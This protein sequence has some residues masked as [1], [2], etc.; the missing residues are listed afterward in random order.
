MILNNLGK[1][2]DGSVDV[3]ADIGR[4]AR[5]VQPVKRRLQQLERLLQH[6]QRL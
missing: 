5:F 3:G 6:P 4:S 1:A 2:V